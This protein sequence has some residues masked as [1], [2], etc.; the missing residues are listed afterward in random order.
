MTV[1]QQLIDALEG[2]TPQRTPLS[3]YDWV[4]GAVTGDEL[5]RAMQ[6]DAWRRL[7]DAGL[8][9]RHHCNTVRAIERGVETTVTG[10]TRDGSVYR[11][12]TKTTPVGSISKV[13][14]DGW[15]HED[16]IKTPHDYKVQQWIVE[17][18][19]LEPDYEAFHRAEEVVGNDGVVALCGSRLWQH[20]TP[21]MSINVDWAGTGRFCMDVASEVTE[22]HELY[23][24]ARKLFL[25]EQRLL[26]AGPGRYVVWFENLTVN[27]LGPRRYDEL[28]MPVYREATPL[29]VE[30]GK[31]VFV[32]YDGALAA[33]A[34]RIAEAPLH[35]VDSL[36]EPPEG[37]MTYDRCRAAWPGLVFW[38]NI[39]V[40]LYDR[41]ADEL[42]QAVI[43]KR[44]RAGT[45]GLAFEISEQ[46]PANWRES[47]P[48]VLQTLEDL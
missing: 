20:R 21:A 2:G 32:H 37:D 47:I 19:E 28:L 14:R 16:W 31:R 13:T 36:T 1:R 15:H 18:T 43:D 7:F 6:D 35:G 44:D 24:A 4:M 17:H 26:A 45:R 9:V 48:V 3:A 25:G 38:A 29:L 30:G 5:E 42:A 40:G 33:I 41:P 11:T 27:M 46:L 23:E 22:L 10:Q 12:E 39:N 34:D 8:G